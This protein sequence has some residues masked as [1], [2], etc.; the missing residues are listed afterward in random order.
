[1]FT[2][3]YLG[4]R[5]IA[6]SQPSI[7]RGRRV[8]KGEN[9]PTPFSTS[10]CLCPPQWFRITPGPCRRTYRPPRL[11]CDHSRAL[12]SLTPEHDP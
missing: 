8:R 6:E 5:C 4:L 1:M 9:T 2:F 7:A 11:A 3:H 12:G 10:G